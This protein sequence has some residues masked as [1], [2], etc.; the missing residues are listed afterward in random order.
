MNLGNDAPTVSLQI[1][2]NAA[3]RLLK[4]YLCK[5]FDCVPTH[6]DRHYIGVCAII[7]EIIKYGHKAKGLVSERD[8]RVEIKRIPS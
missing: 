2:Q 6:T 8:V 7:G 5:S 1:F 3:R 4:S